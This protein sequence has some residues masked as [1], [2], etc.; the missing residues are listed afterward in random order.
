QLQPSAIASPLLIRTKAAAK[1]ARRGGLT[2]KQIFL[3]AILAAALVAPTSQAKIFPS[4]HAR[5]PPATAPA[6][7]TPEWVAGV[8]RADGFRADI[9]VDN[10][11]DPKVTSTTDGTTFTIFF[12]GCH[13][14]RRCESLTFQA[15]FDLDHGMEV[16]KVNSWNK[17]KRFLKAWLDDEN[18]PYVEMDLSVGP[19]SSDATLTGYVSTG[20]DIL[21]KFKRYIDC[22]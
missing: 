12:Y 4:A 18:D 10:D 3:T 19:G 8:L 22:E 16:A 5:R 14:T 9:G 13:G 15:G 2:M 6:G 17:D 7:V 21:P 1:L 20:A 11:G